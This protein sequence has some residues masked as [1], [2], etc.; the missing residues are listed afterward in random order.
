[1]P[2]TE[3]YRPKSKETFHAP[4]YIKALL[5]SETN[6]H[7][8]LYGPPGTG[9]TTFAL[10]LS[11][12]RLEL[13]ASDERGIATVRDKIKTYA[14]TANKRQTIILDECECLTPDAQQALRRIIEDYSANTR[15]IFI[16]NYLSKVIAPL[17]SRLL[18]IKFEITQDC[19]EFLKNI[20]QKEELIV[21]NAFY[22]DLL[23][24]C[25]MD[26]R[27]AVNVLQGIA[28]FI[29]EIEDVEEYIGIVPEN[30]I[31]NFFKIS[32]KN[33]LDFVKSFIRKCYEILQFLKQISLWQIE[34]ENWF[35]FIIEISQAESRAVIGCSIE[36][37]LLDLCCKKIILL[38]E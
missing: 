25:G 38:G 16:T 11:D 19:S 6:Q 36:L 32:K 18:K 29:A 8:L 14:A 22:D 2:W 12:R 26:L 10:L 15:F 35:N 27:K 20:G 31:R 28:P 30:V 23:L 17:K 5:T 33:Y 4:D 34:N 21:E 3:K 13:N 1:M 7:L 24:K 37:I 9:K